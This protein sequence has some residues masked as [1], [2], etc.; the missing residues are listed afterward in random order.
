MSR[1]LDRSQAIFD[2]MPL[3]SSDPIVESGSNA[4]GEFT[5]FADGTQ[6]CNFSVT[7]DVVGWSASGQVFVGDT[8]YAWTFPSTFVGTPIPNATSEGGSVWMDVGGV[9]TTTQIALRHFATTGTAATSHP[10][11][12]SASGRWK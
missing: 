3:V 4:D 6:I 1:T 8:S 12:L 5:K 10:L 11:Y 2:K 9:V 7:H